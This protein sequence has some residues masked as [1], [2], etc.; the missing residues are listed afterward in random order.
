MTDHL[1][2]SIFGEHDEHLD[3]GAE[4]DHPRSGVGAGSTPASV[5]G[6]ESAERRSGGRFSRRSPRSD[7]PRRSKP[8]IWRR[9]V[10]IVLALAV[11]GG[12]AAVA[13]VVLRPMVEGLLES[14]DYPGPG[15]GEVRVTVAAGSGGST[16]A[17]LLVKDGVVK[18]SKAFNEAAAADPKASGIQ[19]GVYQLKEQMKAS[20]ALDLLVDPANRI[21]TRVVIPEGLWATEIYAKLSQQTGIPVAKYV[22]AAK[23]G[24]ELGLPSSAKD[25]VEGYLFPATYEF[26]P[27]SSPTD[28]LA[29]MVSQSTKRLAAL[30]ITPAKM[31]RVVI[32]AS[33]VEAEASRPADRPKVARVVENRLA[34]GMPL[35]LDST[36]SYAAGRRSAT[37]TNQE[38]ASNSP[39]NTYK[40]AG[41]PAGP[42]SNPGESAIEAAVKPAAGDWTYFVTVN[43]TTGETKF[44]SDYNQ[45]LAN[46]KEFQAW[47]QANKGKC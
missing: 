30:G 46:V 20:E 8:S 31:E 32:L 13:F 19:P 26:D 39:Y 47:C 45:H 34:A 17:D 2:S 22:A 23:N 35:Q 33:L 10:V 27:A 9:L 16:I 21:I 40:V 12:G 24:A 18:T 7:R 38:R 36:V 43:P 11:V 14:N 6:A 15:E 4:R 3:L 37:T 42:I 28:Q 1:E 29:Q 44:T 25:N 41:L 5:V